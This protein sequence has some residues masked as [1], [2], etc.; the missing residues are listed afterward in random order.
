MAVSQD[1]THTMRTIVTE[2]MSA[3]RFGNPGIAVLATPVLV[4]L[5]E[6]CCI[7]LLADEL[8]A[9]QGSVG[10]YVEIEHLAPTPFGFEVS[11]S[12]RVSAVEGRS[13]TFDVTARDGR[14]DIARV[15]HKR[16]LINVPKFLERIA[17]KAAA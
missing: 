16:A 9:S 10:T 17:V 2:D 7:E 4:G 1:Q 12:A 14:D 6:R 11:V 5:V 13:V 15:T 8:D 3:E